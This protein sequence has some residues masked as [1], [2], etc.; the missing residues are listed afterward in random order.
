MKLYKLTSFVAL[1]VLTACSSEEITSLEGN[2][3]LRLTS[4]IENTRVATDD[5]S[6]QS[7]R[8]VPGET[9]KVWVEDATTDDVLY[10]AN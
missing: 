8:L 2:C 9:V 6:T 3:E 4:T 7:K 10:E 1:A 5:V